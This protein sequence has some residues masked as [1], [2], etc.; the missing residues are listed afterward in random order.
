MVNT[1]VFWFRIGNANLD[2]AN[3]KDD[4]D[5]DH[6]R[7]DDNDNNDI[8]YNNNCDNLAAINDYNNDGDDDDD[9]DDDDDNNNNNDDHDDGNYESG[10]PILT[11]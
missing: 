6:H 4:V 1:S 2:S 9:D 11:V 8:D 7:H 3:Y 5:H 10:V